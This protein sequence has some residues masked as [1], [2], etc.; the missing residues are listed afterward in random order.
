MARPLRDLVGELI[1]VRRGNV[2]LFRGLP[3]EAWL[4]TGTASGGRF[5]ARAM[6]F[7]IAGHERHHV[8]ILRERYA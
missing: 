7:I 3:E 6:P 1:H 5:V 2:H 4:R 8:A